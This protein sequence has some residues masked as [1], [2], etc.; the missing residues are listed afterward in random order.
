M[1]KLLFFLVLS[2]LFVFPFAA[3]A[4]QMNQ[5]GGAGMPAPVTGNM[6]NSLGQDALNGILSNDQQSVAGSVYDQITQLR[7]EFEKA[8][9]E[10]KMGLAMRIIQK[11]R[12][13][14]ERQKVASEID[15]LKQ[16]VIDQ[17]N[18]GNYDAALE[19]VKKI[20]KIEHK[21]WAF[22]Q[23]GRIYKAL[24]RDNRPHV[25]A[26][27]AEVQ[28]DVPPVIENGRTLIPLRAVA[29]ALGIGNEAIS[30]N[31]EDNLVTINNNNTVINLPVDSQVVTVNGKAQR[32]DVPAVLRGNRVLVPL[33]FVSQ[34]LGKPVQW[35]PE[36][37]I[38]AVGAQ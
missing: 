21:G 26:N 17:V 3:F 11:L 24:G 31:Q 16:Q 18:Q 28:S 15:Q 9:Q 36:G 38:V 4:D 22:Q 32:I 27:G 30:W 25:F 37:Q 1:R 7:Q 20:L 12:R 5:P 2:A 33:R 14:E 34:V 35:Y 10:D 6:L 8:V 19:T 23:L 13:L 29:N